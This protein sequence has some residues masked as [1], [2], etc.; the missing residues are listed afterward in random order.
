MVTISKPPVGF[1]A[2]YLAALGAWFLVTAIG[3]GYVVRDSIA[4]VEADFNR[5]TESAIAELRDKLKANEAV[6]AGFSSFLS[7]V[8]ANDRASVQHYASLM[9]ATYPHIYMLEVAREVHREDR[10]EFESYL[11]RN[12][13]RSFNIRSFSY[14]GSRTW[15]IAPDKPTYQPI[16]FIWPETEEARPVVGLD[17]DSVPHLREALV[18]A[19][20]RRVAISSNPFK[21][22]EGDDAYVMF[23]HTDRSVSRSSPRPEYGFA[24]PLTALLVMKATDLPPS[25]PAPLTAHRL[26]VTRAGKLLEPPLYDVP[27]ETQPGRLEAALFP[28]LRLDTSDLSTSQPMQLAVER[29]IRFTDLNGVGLTLVSLFSL[30]FL[31]L[32]VAYLRGHNRNIAYALALERQAEYLAL[33]DPLTGLPN[34]HLLEDRVRQVL[35]TWRRHG[36]GFA[37]LFVDIDKFKE[38]ND[39]HGHAAGDYLL[40]ELSRRLVDAVRASDTVTRYGG[41]EFIVLIS[42][43]AND[44]DVLTV[45]SKILNSV[46]LPYHFDP[47][48]LNVTASLG[49]SRCPQDGQDYH[50]LLK[51][52]D[53][54]M[55]SVKRGTTGSPRQESPQGTA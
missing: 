49:I 21:L 24:G 48:T 23:R 29:Q 28:T 3:I 13:G 55:Y 26:Q 25:A 4:A 17:M 46:S 45:S 51:H 32:L 15:N 9:L 54:A 14:D 37:L 52:A 20:L 40:C 33:H 47:V 50:T 6:L 43:V 30:L 44:D 1:R 10:H 34:R 36:V 42:D 18:E 22:V 5:Y 7:A 11:R 53:A 41:D 16:V 27:P 31:V 35:A 8:E 38:I 12:W 19:R 39:H 2:L